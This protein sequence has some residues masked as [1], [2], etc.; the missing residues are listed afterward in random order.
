[1]LQHGKRTHFDRTDFLCVVLLAL[2]IAAVW[3]VAYGRGDAESWA[4]PIWYRGDALFLLSY[5]KAARD[6]HVVPAEAL[7]VPE[8]NAPFG[9]NWNDHPRTLRPVFLAGGLLARKL[10]LFATMN[11]MLLGA[12][13]LAG[14]ALYLVARYFRARREWALVAG[15]AFGLSHYLFWRSLDH[16]DLALGWHI[17]LCVMV[18][19][20]AFSRRGIPWRSRRLAVAAA[21]A[22]LAAF[23]NPYYSALFGQFLCLGALAQALRRERAKAVVL[24]GLVGVLAVSFLVD[25]AGVAAFQWRH[26]RNAGAERGYGGLERYCLKPLELFVPPIGFG[27][28]DWGRLANEYWQRRLYKGEGGSPYLGLLGGGTLAWLF[29]LTLVR[30]LRRPPRRP[31]PA[32][33]AVLWILAYS[34]LGGINQVLGLLGFVWLRGANR[35]SIWIL[36]LVLLYL[37][38]RRGVSRKASLAL[39]GAACVLCIADQVPRWGDR[40]TIRRTRLAIEGDRA[41]VRDAEQVL[42]PGAMVFQL[43]LVD[44]PEGLPLPGMG[45]YEPLRPYLFSDRLRWS[46]GSDRGRRREHWQLTVAAKPP[47]DMAAA[48]EACGF[49]GILVHRAAA[50]DG[51]VLAGLAAAG[52]PVRVTSAAGD[53]A[54]VPLH[55]RVPAPDPGPEA[56]LEEGARPGAWGGEACAAALARPPGAP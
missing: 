54:L 42:P 2:A 25:H 34:I 47:A 45:A 37:A 8:L 53:F 27:L 38:T 23:H 52:R 35:Y 16:L 32:A 19:A 5:L 22:V 44:F 18:V 56:A 20:W 3:C 1:M 31:P 26:G 6:G 41:F 13:V 55:P 28:D 30:V 43:P 7:F 40:E 11:L 21:V 51:G 4:T 50:V 14:I 24:A 12:H 46:F 29:G 39:S 36:A 9:A 10:G 33:L 15:L 49:A 48:L 17:P